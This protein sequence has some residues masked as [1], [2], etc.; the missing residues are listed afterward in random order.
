VGELLDGLGCVGTALH[1]ESE[2]PPLDSTLIRDGGR[3]ELRTATQ[4]ER[5]PNLL[6]DPALSRQKRFR[7]QDEL[8]P[9][10]ARF[11]RPPP[12]SLLSGEAKLSHHASANGDGDRY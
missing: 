1:G 9:V 4:M 2:E 6:R 8:T 3:R 11:H 10:Q 12:V 5:R 7:P